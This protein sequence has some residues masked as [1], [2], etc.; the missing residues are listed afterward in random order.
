MTDGGFELGG[1][2]LAREAEGDLHQRF[3]DPD[4]D[5]TGWS[6]ITV[7][8]H[9]R[10]TPALRRERRPGPLPAPVPGHAAGRGPA[11]VPD[12]RRRLLLRGRVARRRLPRR[13]RGVLRPPH[14][15]DHRRRPRR[16]GEHVL[17][18]EV[19]CPRE[20]DRRAKRMVTGVFSHWD[21]LDPEWNPGGLWRPVRVVESGPGPAGR[22]PLPVHRGHRGP[23]PARSLSLT[24]DSPAGADA[25]SA[26]GR[27]LD[28][29][30]ATSTPSRNRRWPPAST[31]SAG[32][33]RSTTRPAGGPGATAPQPLV[34]VRSSVEVD[35]VRSDGRRLPHRLPGGA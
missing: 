26:C 29:P 17:A 12:L 10:S 11:A 14:L 19:A 34:D 6:P 24:V 16:G 32:R 9:W 3:V 8:G 1:S 20:G 35:G 25:R 30:G 22:L 15:R 13:D 33:S 31:T 28:G 4:F 2:W 21:V 23:G 27:R 7:P 5:D 18:V